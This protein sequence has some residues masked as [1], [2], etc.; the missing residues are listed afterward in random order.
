MKAAFFDLDGC[1]VDSRVPISGSINAALRELGVPEQPASELHRYIGPPLLVGFGQIL[2]SVGADPGLAARAVDAYRQ[3][4][5]DLSIRQ[6][7]PVPGMRELL[8]RLEGSLTLM[9]VT[10]KPVEFAEPVLEAVGMRSHF[11]A[12]LGPGLDALSE[13]KA[14]KLAQALALAAIA[15][16]ERATAAAMIG[17]REHDVAAGRVCGTATI[18]V[19]WGIGDRQEL[20]EAGADLIVDTPDELAGCLSPSRSAG[21]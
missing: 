10:S 8:A 13:P 6:T 19:T 4:Y 7:S 9:V 2:A 3:V 1:L 15:D 17:D 20:S 14:D 5:P 18:G 16:D 11:S 12:V 21:R